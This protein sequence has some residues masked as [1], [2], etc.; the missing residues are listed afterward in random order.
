[1]R[2]LVV[3][4]L[5]TSAFFLYNCEKDKEEASKLNH[6]ETLYGGCN[7]ALEK[8]SALDGE[9]DTVMVSMANDTLNI[10][11]GVN[12]I[13]CATFEGK[14][15]TIDDTLQIT[16]SDICTP[17]DMCYCH[18][19]CYYTF[20]FRYTGLEAGDYPCK[21]QLWDAR[22]EKFILLFAGTIT[23]RQV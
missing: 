15:A 22:E 23:I 6:A 18:C 17:D 10:H 11:V 2:N 8:S 13:C 7:N 12:Y 5:L 14:S 9:N 16:V 21:V 20:D 1:M 19:M 4:L 3:L